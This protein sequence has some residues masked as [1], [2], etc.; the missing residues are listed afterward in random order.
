MLDPKSAGE[1]WAVV[2]RSVAC[3]FL[4]AV[5]IAVAAAFFVG[6]YMGGL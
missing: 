4:I 6:Y 1:I 2:F 3:G 5:L